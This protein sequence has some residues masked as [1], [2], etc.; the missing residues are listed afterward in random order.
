[1]SIPIIGDIVEGVSGTVQSY[2]D[3]KKERVKAKAKAE[4]ETTQARAQ[5]LI[6]RVKEEGASTRQAIAAEAGTKR[7]LIRKQM[8]LMRRVT[9]AVLLM[10]LAV[11][12]LIILATYLQAWW[13]GAAPDP[14]FTPLS[15]FWSQVVDG[16]PDW[17]VQAL[18]GVFAFL[19]AGGEVTNVGAQAGG[20]V[21][22]QLK[23]NR[24][25]KERE[26]KEARKAEREKRNRERESRGEAPLPDDPEAADKGRRTIP[27]PPGGGP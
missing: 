14:D 6:T 27:G 15:L 26:A 16:T 12:A 19:W 18:Q 11:G 23:A 3:G 20:A 21:L 24:D 7:A 9:L 1:M 17:W 5:Q 25:A 10:P 22:D 13:S 2:F 4:I 8:R